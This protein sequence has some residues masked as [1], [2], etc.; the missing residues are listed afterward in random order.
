[1]QMSK[2]SVDGLT[3]VQAR[4]LLLI[5][6]LLYRRQSGSVLFKKLPKTIKE[7]FTRMSRLVLIVVCLSFLFLWLVLI[8]NRKIYKT[9]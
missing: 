6:P 7:A 4:D 2:Q 1:M 5:S 3:R 9:K 8:D